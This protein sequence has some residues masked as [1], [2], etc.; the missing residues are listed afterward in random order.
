MF[1]LQAGAGGAVHQQVA[2]TALPPGHIPAPVRGFPYLPTETCT[3]CAKMK[4]TYDIVCCVCVLR[5]TTL[6]VCFVPRALYFV[7]SIVNF[8]NE[9]LQSIVKYKP[10]AE[11]I[12]QH[13]STLQELNSR[14]KFANRRSIYA[15]ASYMRLKPHTNVPA[16]RCTYYIRRFFH[17]Q[18]ESRGQAGHLEYSTL[19]VELVPKDKIVYI[20]TVFA[21]KMSKSHKQI[22]CVYPKCTSATQDLAG[23]VNQYPNLPTISPRIS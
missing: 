12:Y 9:I 18:R 15:E 5:A 23:V 22:S 11:I 3:R 19:P 4:P 17:A 13:K 2:L 7:L 10:E 1:R 16:A 21:V 8:E 6:L 14:S 20:S